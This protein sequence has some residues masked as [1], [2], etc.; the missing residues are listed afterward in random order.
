MPFG[1]SVTGRYNP[2]GARQPHTDVAGG[3]D[4]FQVH[5]P[6]QP[7]RILTIDDVVDGEDVVP[8]WSSPV[9]ELFE[10]L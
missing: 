8:G 1:A 6:G 5:R 9:R 3:E 10:E 4:G 7:V 2:A